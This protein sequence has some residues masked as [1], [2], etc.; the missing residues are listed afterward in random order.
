M[1]AILYKLE[2]FSLSLFYYFLRI[3]PQG[4]NHVIFQS[5][6]IQQKLRESVKFFNPKSV[7]SSLDPKE[8]K[9]MGTKN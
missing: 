1:Y 6:Y 5:F 7:N 9:T 8:Q 2:F 4:R 3:Q